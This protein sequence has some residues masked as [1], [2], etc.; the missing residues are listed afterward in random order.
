MLC[1]EILPQCGFDENETAMIKEAIMHHRR[2]DDE[3]DILLSEAL[4]W[5]DKKSRKC[6]ECNM[7]RECNW[8]IDRMNLDIEY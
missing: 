2:N 3:S 6:F 7:R 5:A 1:D 8:E 4:Y